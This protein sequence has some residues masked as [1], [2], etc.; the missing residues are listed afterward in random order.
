M[1]ANLPPQYFEAEKHFREAK[2][3][4]DKIRALEAMLSIMPKHKGTDKLRAELRSKIAKLTDEAQ[5]AHAASRRGFSHYVYKEGAGQVALV[6]LP[7]VGKSQLVGALTNAKPEVADYPFTTHYAIPGM[8]PFENIQIQL[9]DLPS[10]T[11]VN[12]QS[13]LPMVLKNADFL[14]IMV[15]QGDDCMGQMEMIGHRLEQMGIRPVGRSGDVATDEG[16]TEKKALI[17]AN[18]SDL[19]ATGADYAELESQYEGEF[20]TISLSATQGSGLE[21][22]KRKLFEVLDVIRVYTKSPG[23]KPNLTQPVILRSMSTVADAAEAIHKDFRDKLKHAQV[24]GSGKFDGQM[25]KRDHVL[26][27][28]DIIEFRI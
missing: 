19:A 1:P 2:S 4:P 27:D 6:G 11:D 21:E 16:L 3:I 24:W 9:V 10:V 12:A 18:K 15:D 26:K 22:L 17:V 20:P 7:N 23:Q 8:M 25:V 13:W 5:K 28:G 14:L